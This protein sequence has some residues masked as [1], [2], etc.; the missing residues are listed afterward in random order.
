MKCEEY[1]EAMADLLADVADGDLMAACRRHEAE[2]P[3]CA[4][5]LADFRR[6]ETL[7]RAL[8][9]PPMPRDPWEGIREA[10]RRPPGRFSAPWGWAAAALLLLGLG[11]GLLLPRV[12]R[13]GV[14]V[15]IVDVQGG[16]F[17]AFDGMIPGYGDSEA[18]TLLVSWSETGE[19]EGSPR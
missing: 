18:R 11:V 7:L 19:G 3:E 4:G 9:V 16:A 17:E 6:N 1:R 13:A 12:P 15:E 8:P 5:L 14:E 10:V 2:C